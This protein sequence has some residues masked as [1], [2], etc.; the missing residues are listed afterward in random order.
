MEMSSK[1]IVSYEGGD[2]FDFEEFLYEVGLHIQRRFPEGYV[3]CKAENMG[4]LRRSG[5]KKFKFRMDI[6]CIE[7]AR[8]FL[9]EFMPDCE[10][11][12]KVYSLNRGKGLAFVVQHHDNPVDGD[13]YYCTPIKESTYNS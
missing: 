7:V 11:H 12:T 13:R 2:E 5:Y 9:Y 10:W 4:W 1:P 8:N 3:M 6:N